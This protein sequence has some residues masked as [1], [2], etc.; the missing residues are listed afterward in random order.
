MHDYDYFHLTW[1]VKDSNPIT[2]LILNGQFHK[3]VKKELLKQCQ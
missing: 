1:G 3:I 2:Y